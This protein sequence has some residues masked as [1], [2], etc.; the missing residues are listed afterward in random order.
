MD[1][2]ASGRRGDGNVFHQSR[3]GKKLQNG[4]LNLPPACPH[5]K[6]PGY[7]VP[8]FFVADGAFELSKHIVKP[9][10]TVGGYCSKPH[11]LFNY[12]VSR[13]RHPVED[14]FGLLYQR[15][16]VFKTV[17]ECNRVSARW[18][19]KACCA[20]HN[21]HL[22]KEGNVA[23]R[24]KRQSRKQYF[25]YNNGETLIH[26]RYKNEDPEREL[27]T[28]NRLFMNVDLARASEEDSEEEEILDGESIREVLL[29]HFI[30]DDSVPW[31]WS[32]ARL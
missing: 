17:M 7:K 19:T 20:L 2:G 27:E 25:D 8:F 15:L 29:D 18:I 14:A 10:K 16:E 30:E 12:R 32:K 3:F 21:Y 4:Q 23:P 11:R 5:D 31:Q 26:G 6:I 28:L 24:R 13:S 1:V 22:I 9:F